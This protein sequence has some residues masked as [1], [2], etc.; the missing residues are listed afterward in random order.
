M[1]QLTLVSVYA[2]TFRESVSDKESLFHDLQL[3][4]D[5]VAYQMFLGDWNA[6]HWGMVCRTEPRVV[7]EAGLSL[8]SSRAFTTLFDPLTFILFLF[9]LKL[10][11]NPTLTTL[12]DPVILF[13]FF[14]LKIIANHV[15]SKA[16]CHAKARPH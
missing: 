4:I 2:P 6:C 5:G 15:H 11:T 8:L 9:L 1:K 16:Y 3:V 10:I 13:L 12:F 7:N 14:L